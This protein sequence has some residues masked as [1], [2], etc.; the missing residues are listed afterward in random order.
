MDIGANMEEGGQHALL[1]IA[2]LMTL[3]GKGSCLETSPPTI[4]DTFSLER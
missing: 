1:G 4:A 2:T 3:T